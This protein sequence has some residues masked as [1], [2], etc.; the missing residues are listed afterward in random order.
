MRHCSYTDLYKDSRLVEGEDYGR[1]H[2]RHGRFDDDLAQQGG[3][4]KT[5][6]IAP[7]GGGI[8]PGTSELCL[9][10][11]GYHPATLEV[12]PPGGVTYDYWMFEG[13]R[14]SDN[15]ELHVTSTA[16]DDGVALSLCGGALNALTL[17]GCTP[18][19]AGEEE[20]TPIV[21]VGGRNQ[22]L[23][24]YLLAAFAI[25]DPKVAAKDAWDIRALNGD[26][27]DNIVNRTLLGMGGHL[28]LTTPLRLAMFEKNTRED[29][30]NT[31]TPV[32]WAF[33]TACRA[34]LARLEAEQVV[35]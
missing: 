26:D 9:A 24:Q 8:E 25:A 7:H 5:A 3:V 16:C 23:K 27:A 1:R 4:D 30:K 17:H 20:G 28:E 21:L 32:F 35:L 31:T 22:T 29:R 2:R 15:D 18:A 19:A 12:T 33:V 13:L 10:I 6:V 11:A 34:A 14:G